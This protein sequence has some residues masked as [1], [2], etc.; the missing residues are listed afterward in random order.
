M[1]SASDICQ[2]SQCR[3]LQ[4][5]VDVST[6]AA[7]KQHTKPWI[8]DWLRSVRIERDVDAAAVA[9][10][11]NLHP[12]GITRR[13]AGELHWRANDIPAVLAAYDIT[14]SQFIARLK[15]MMPKGSLGAAS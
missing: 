11:L 15:Q 4:P 13:E 14:P 5:I 1:G 2:D 10:K 12:S 9:A 7:M 8:G 6:M 3:I